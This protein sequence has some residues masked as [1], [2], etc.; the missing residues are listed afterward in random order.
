MEP[1]SLATRIHQQAAQRE[2]DLTFPLA[3]FRRKQRNH[4][5]SERLIQRGDNQ[6]PFQS[7]QLA[8]SNFQSLPMEVRPAD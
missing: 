3:C 1:K 5:A 8:H 4:T 6:I 2:P 7:G